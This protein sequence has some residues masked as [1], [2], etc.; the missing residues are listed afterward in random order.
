[1]E[2]IT[3]NKYDILE[4]GY[5]DENHNYIA[6]LNTDKLKELFEADEIILEEQY[7]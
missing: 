7:K 3:V 2:L 5:Y 4:Y 6:K 1:M